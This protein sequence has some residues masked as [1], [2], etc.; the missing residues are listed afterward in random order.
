MVDEE[1]RRWIMENYRAGYTPE[2]LK[3]SLY[4]HGND[5]GIVDEVLGLEPD[6]SP[7][8]PPPPPEG[9]AAQPPEPREEEDEGGINWGIVL[10]IVVVGLFIAALV[11]FAGIVSGLMASVSSA[12]GPVAAP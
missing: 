7:E 12:G 11:W 4:S 9:A 5:P 2:Q 6:E 10:A 3:K 8:M 1:L